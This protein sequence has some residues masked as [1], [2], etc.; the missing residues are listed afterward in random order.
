MISISIFDNIKGKLTHQKQA[1][2]IQKEII[3]S[4]KQGD[5]FQNIIKDN[6][7]IVV[8]WYHEGQCGK[9]LY[10]NFYNQLNKLV[11]N[12]LIKEDLNT[13]IESIKESKHF[14]TN[15]QNLLLFNAPNEVYLWYLKGRDGDK[16]FEL[17]YNAVKQYAFEDIIK[18]DEKVL[19]KLL[20]EGA[21]LEAALKSPKVFSTKQEFKNNCYGSLKPAIEKHSK[22]SIIEGLK[23]GKLFNDLMESGDIYNTPNEIMEWYKQGRKGNSNHEDFYKQ[24][25]PFVAKQDYN[26]L[27]KAINDGFSI[28]KL[29]TLPNLI[30]SEEEICEYFPKTD[31]ES[32]E[33]FI[34]QDTQK[35]ILN[36][37]L[38]GMSFKNV[39]KNNFLKVNPKDIVIWY[40]L[41][42]GGDSKYEKFFNEIS[43]Y[44]IK[45]DCETILEDVKKGNSLNEAIENNDLL[46]RKDHI[47]HLYAENEFINDEIS[48]I[49][50]ETIELLISN[51]EYSPNFDFNA[52]DENVQQWIELGKLNIKPF[53]DFYDEYLIYKTQNEVV[54]ALK[55]NELFN[56]AINQSNLSYN[57]DE[58]LKWF[59]MG[60]NGEKYKEFY[61][62]CEEYTIAETKQ[63]IIGHLSM[64]RSFNQAIKQ[65]N[66]LYNEHEIRS[67]FSSGKA[68]ENHIEF[69]QQCM[70]IMSQF[71]DTIA[72]LDD[73]LTPKYEERLKLANLTADDYDAIIDEIYE[74]ARP[75]VKFEDDDTIFEKVS[76]IVNAYVPWSYKSRGG[77]LGF[78]RSNSIK[79]DDRLLDS[80]K[81]STLIHEL[82]HHFVAEILESIICYMLDVEKTQ[83]IEGFIAFFLIDP[84][85]KIMN[86]Y[87]ASTVEG[88]F[89]PHGFQNYG[90]FPV[91]LW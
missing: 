70:G 47:K 79:L 7:E 62:E 30:S 89:I 18:H 13:V 24:A 72:S 45:D 90:A 14:S 73:L 64:Y 44:V 9:D 60:K 38:E 56:N 55:N 6:K 91:R 31:N 42:R 26:R 52:S 1:L 68:G 25:L 32:Y 54:D 3:N 51:T 58:I 4:I 28:D 23:K 33:T 27:S 77:E 50:H 83:A 71:K 35:A 41:G 57:S 88:R 59:F 37:C 20:N 82:T 66:S 11:N 39:I 49:V 61:D 19:S 2:Q 63:K 43:P 53:K 8:K 15:I 17:L 10:S 85:S 75:L 40:K 84:L 46:G 81:I 78:Y 34:E 69:Y 21:D 86:E 65:H 67:W 12:D 36:S 22:K 16:K 74:M 48:S 5:S 76:K 80:Q 87:C 29:V